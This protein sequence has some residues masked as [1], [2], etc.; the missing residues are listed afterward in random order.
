[1]PPTPVR[2]R[3]WT[4]R[5][6][7]HSS[8]TSRQRDRSRIEP[9]AQM[10]QRRRRDAGKPHDHASRW[11]MVGSRAEIDGSGHD[12]GERSRWHHAAQQR[13]KPDPYGTVLNGRLALVAGDLHQRRPGAERRGKLRGDHKRRHTNQPEKSINGKH[14]YRSPAIKPPE[15]RLVRGL[16]GPLFVDQHPVGKN[17]PGYRQQRQNRNDEQCLHGQTLGLNCGQKRQSLVFSWDYSRK[18]CG[19]RP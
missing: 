7:R 5:P 3:A 2:R 17:C 18:D 19:Q 14:H 10:A 9:S 13:G 4:P 8:M 1:M 12:L 15:S 11:A 16:F 6:G